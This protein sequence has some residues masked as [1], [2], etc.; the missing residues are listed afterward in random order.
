MC[1]CSGFW[2]TTCGDCYWQENIDSLWQLHGCFDGCRVGYAAAA[3]QH[4]VELP[5]AALKGA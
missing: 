3:L 2:D 4:G 1:M 5:A